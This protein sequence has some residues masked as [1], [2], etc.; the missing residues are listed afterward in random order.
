MYQHNDELKREKRAIDTFV[1]LFD[2]S[3]QKLDPN[4]IDYKVFDKDNNLIAYAEVSHRIRTL[5]DAYPLFISA[6][7]V[8]K[9]TEKRL[10]PVVIWAC[11]DGIIYS[12]VKHLVGEIRWG[13]SAFFE[14]TSP[15]MD[16]LIM[17]FDKQKGM[18]Y[19][20]YQS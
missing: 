2:G 17:Y 6:K 13:Q 18:K 16:E 20:R 1:S 19:I 14:Q 7:K 11:E 10:N 4:D 9:L 3:Y 8:I 15:P 12:K 5:R